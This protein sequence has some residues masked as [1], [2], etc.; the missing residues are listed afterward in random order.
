MS[1]DGDFV[2]YLL[3]LL[4]PL[5]RC[6]ARRM[7]GGHG[8]YGDGLMFA[9]VFDGRLYL[10]VDEVAKPE[11][12]AVGCAPFVYSG[13]QNPIEMS[14]WT[15]PESALESSEQMRPWARLAMAAALRK[16][17]ARPAM[18]QSAPKKAAAKKSVAK[19]SGSKKKS[20]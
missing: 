19:K 14:Y 20:R 7:F 2:A 15:V 3:E 4:Q 9:L 8:I 18:K 16:A 13:Q 11:F 5:A 17:N 6:S 12:A 1:D 10:K